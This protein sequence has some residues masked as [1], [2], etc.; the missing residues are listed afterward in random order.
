MFFTQTLKT[1]NTPCDIASDGASGL[2]QVTKRI[3]LVKKAISPNYRLIL[4]DYNMPN[5]PGTEVATRICALYKEARIQHPKLFC[6]TSEEGEKF[7]QAVLAS[8]ML[9]TLSKPLGI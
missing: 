3:E 9:G 6:C 7:N 2:E 4:I 5:M 1:L 8:G